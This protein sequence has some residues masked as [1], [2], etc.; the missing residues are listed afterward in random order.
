MFIELKGY[1]EVVETRKYFNAAH[2]I[3]IQI[4]GDDKNVTFCMSG[5]YSNFAHTFKTKEE[6]DEFLD[7]F[8]RLNPVINLI[9]GTTVDTDDT[10]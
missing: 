8:L 5:A 6:R 1:K 3:A 4:D 9:E 2:V 10:D 7:M